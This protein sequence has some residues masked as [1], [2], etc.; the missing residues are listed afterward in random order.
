MGPIS[1][2]ELP[3]RGPHVAGGRH[4][5]PPLWRLANLV[6]TLAL[7]VVAIG[8]SVPTARWAEVL[9]VT[10]GQTRSLQALLLGPAVT[11]DMKFHLLRAATFFIALLLL[12]GVVWAVFAWYSKGRALSEPQT[13]GERLLAEMGALVAGC[14]GLA[15][16]ATAS[17]TALT[18][19]PAGWP[20]AAWSCSGQRQ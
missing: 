4:S 6:C 8:F 12:L 7:G 19:R 2:A 18:F 3:Q 1:L 9:A 16:W 20:K 10:P 15:L 17:L 11:V 13:L 5:E 14:G